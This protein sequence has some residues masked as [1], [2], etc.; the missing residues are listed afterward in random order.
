MVNNR[1]RER[2]RET[3]TVQK[4][5]DRNGNEQ[6]GKVMAPCLLEKDECTNTE[7]KNKRAGKN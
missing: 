7:R 3:S 2:G 5:E 4:T 1:K 6:E